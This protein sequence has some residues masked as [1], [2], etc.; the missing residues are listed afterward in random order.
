M[1][2]GAAKTRR[3][4]TAA[5]R[6]FATTYVMTRD[7]LTIFEALMADELD[8]GALELSIPHPLTGSHV[9]A[10]IMTPYELATDEMDIAVSFTLEILPA[11]THPMRARSTVTFSLSASQSSISDLGIQGYALV[12]IVLPQGFQGSLIAIEGGYDADSIVETYLA[13]EGVANRATVPIPSA[14]SAEPV[15]IALDV[16]QIMIGAGAVRLISLQANGTTPQTQSSA[17]TVQLVW[18]RI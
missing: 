11:G 13:D 4:Y 12:E 1:S 2:T 17:R 16:K 8:D 10:R 5:P 15:S 6:F 9:N 18:A 3:R 7:Q 14:V